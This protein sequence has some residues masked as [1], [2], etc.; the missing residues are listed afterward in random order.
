M[1]CTAL[2]LFSQEFFQQSLTP[3]EGCSAM[4]V[5]AVVPLYASE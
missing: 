3:D 5:V 1:V 4:A 2:D